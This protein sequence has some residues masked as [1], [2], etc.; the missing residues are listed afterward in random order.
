LEWGDTFLQEI[1]TQG[2]VLYESIDSWMDS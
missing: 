1:V 2:K